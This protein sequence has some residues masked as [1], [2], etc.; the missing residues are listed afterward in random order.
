MQD[1][2]DAQLLREFAEGRSEPAFRQIVRRH[3]DLVYSAALRH[4]ESSDLAC[5]IAQGV[6]IDL[7]RK[8]RPLTKKMA[9]S[10]SLV[11]WLYVSTRYAALN[12]LRDDRRRLAHERLAMEQ[13]ITNSESAPDWERIRPVLDEA[14]ADLSDQD[15]EALLLRYFKNHDFRAVGHALGLSDDAAQKRVSRAVER[16]REFFAKRGVTVGGSGL[17][18]IISANAVQAA[19]LALAGTISTAVTAATITTTTIATQTAMHWINIKSMTAIVAAAV[20]AATGTY[21][22]HE[23]EANRLRKEKQSLIAQQEQLTSERDTALSAASQKNNDIEQLRKEK[24]ELPKLRGEIGLLRRQVLELGKLREENARLGAT[25]AIKVQPGSQGFV[26]RMAKIIYRDKHFPKDTWSFAGYADPETALATW[27]WAM[28]KGDRNIMLASLAPEAQPEWQKIFE[29][30]SD[31][32]IAKEFSSSA[33]KIAG[34][35][36]HSRQMISDNEAVIALVMDLP[37]GTQTDEQKMR[38]K[39]FA[40]EWK[41]V[42]PAFRIRRELQ[43]S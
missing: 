38:V 35:T 9:E 43:R 34:Y 3:T 29:G 21:W 13:L 41:I 19:P 22:L 20:A 25:A 39:K 32:E 11:S 27:T 31:E 2:S 1:Q 12:F 15:R 30:K 36:L 18:V 24:S 8:A 23:G 28:N 7:A 40:E 5:D 26:E 37:D 14:M 6:F 10:R 17:V 16:L 42:G 4:V 33:A